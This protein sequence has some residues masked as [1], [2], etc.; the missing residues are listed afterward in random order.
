MQ[1]HSRVYT[2]FQFQKKESELIFQSS[3]IDKTSLI[4]ETFQS[5]NSSTKNFSCC[6]FL[7]SAAAYS[8]CQLLHILIVSCCIFLLSAAA[9]S[10]CQLLYILT[11][12]GP[13]QHV[14]V[15]VDNIISIFEKRIDAIIN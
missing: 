1:L 10:C 13:L 9:Y 8:Y 4:K 11:H 6:I 2:Y 3:T 12:E 5:Y 15:H 7:L 14:D